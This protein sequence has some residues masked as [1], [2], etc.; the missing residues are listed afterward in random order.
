MEQIK[1]NELLLAMRAVLQGLRAEAALVQGS[2]ITDILEL[3]GVTI[4]LARI[5]TGKGN[6]SPS[7]LFLLCEYYKISLSDFFKRVEK[8]NPKLK[9]R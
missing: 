8:E 4:N 9:I 3:K 2:V 6:I 5:E 7:T 1:N